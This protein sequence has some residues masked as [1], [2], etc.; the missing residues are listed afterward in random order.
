MLSPQHLPLPLFDPV[1]LLAE[2]AVA[3]AMHSVEVA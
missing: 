1:E 2:A 3:H